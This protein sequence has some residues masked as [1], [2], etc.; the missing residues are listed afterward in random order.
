[1]QEGTAVAIERG[2]GIL[3]DDNKGSPRNEGGYERYVDT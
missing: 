3:G 1:V 2:I